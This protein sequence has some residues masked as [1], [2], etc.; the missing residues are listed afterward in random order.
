MIGVNKR[1]RWLYLVTFF[2]VILAQ[3]WILYLD[4][5]SIIDMYTTRKHGTIILP[6]FLLLYLMWGVYNLF[7]FINYNRVDKPEVEE[8]YNDYE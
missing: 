1:P 3:V 7:K 8:D 2:I 4:N 6:F 5:W